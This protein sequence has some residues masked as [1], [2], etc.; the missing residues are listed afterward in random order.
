MTVLHRAEGGKRRDVAV[1]VR[2]PDDLLMAA[3][4]WEA[5]GGQAI[6]LESAQVLKESMRARVYRLPAMRG[7]EGVVAKRT[8]REALELLVLREIAPLLPISVPRLLATVDDGTSTWMFME[9]AGDV[10]YVSTTLDHRRA[11]ARL[12]AT[13]HN[14]LDGSFAERLPARRSAHYFAHLESAKQR[15]EAGLAN[16]ELPCDGAA[17]LRSTI[18]LLLHVEHSWGNIE[19]F[20]GR[21]RPTLVHGDLVPKNIAVQDR[22]STLQLLL[23]DWEKAGWGNPAPDLARSRE[24]KLTPNALMNEYQRSAKGYLRSTPRADTA[25]LA[26]L[27]TVYRCLAA[28]DW[29]ST[30]L[31]VQRLRRPLRVLPLY[32]A[33]MAEALGNLGLSP[34]A[35]I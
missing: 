31:A 7:S 12:L 24:A 22:G 4:L 2:W 29:D 1:E 21:A 15:L 13:I 30:R 32:S 28:I 9:D 10:Q 8:K 16:P 33:A 18:D 5:H 25:R 34:T 20:D 3:N 17:T 6:N 23:L 26:H 35:R 11:L 14:N 27:G 19:E